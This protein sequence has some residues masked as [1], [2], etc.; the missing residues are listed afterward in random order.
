VTR[1]RGGKP[2]RPKGSVEK[3]T[4]EARRVFLET[5]SKTMSVQTA[6]DAAGFHYLTFR[7][8]RTDDPSFAAEVEEAK[9]RHYD[10]IEQEIFRRGVLGW[11]EPKFGATGQL[12]TIRRYSDRMLELYAQRRIPAYRSNSAAKMELLQMN[13]YTQ[14][15]NTIKLEDLPEE[16]RR[17]LRALLVSTP[18][19]AVLDVKQEQAKKI[20]SYEDP[21]EMGSYGDTGDA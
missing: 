8:H 18:D 3:F 9:R 14:I 1:K 2:G 19:P 12:G 21:E 16:S 15:N 17:H 5:Y 4:P 20:S 11:D 6:C 7:K 13:S 10:L